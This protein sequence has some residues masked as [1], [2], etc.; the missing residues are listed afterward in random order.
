MSHFS[1]MQSSRFELKYLVSES[2]A[3]GIRKFVRRF[4]VPD[5]HADPSLE[6]CYLVH[7]LYLDSPTLRLFQE[8]LDGLRNRFKLRIRF[9]DDD[10]RHP[11]FLEIKRRSGQVVLKERAAVTR[12]GAASLLER[13]RVGDEALLG[14][15]QRAALAL[16]HFCELTRTIGAQGRVYVSYVREAY[17]APDSNQAR[18]TFDRKL[19]AIPHCPGNGL[20]FREPGVP[21]RQEGVVLELKFTDRFPLWMEELVQRFNLR[22]ISFSKYCRCALAADVPGR[23]KAAYRR[24]Q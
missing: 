15:N 14:E 20:S 6:N 18:V 4:L 11:V 9:Y 5:A 16:D 12:C 24:A 3:C 23:L 19:V 1:G 22:R 21:V 17:V 2:Q 13:G 10:P 8:T 7:S